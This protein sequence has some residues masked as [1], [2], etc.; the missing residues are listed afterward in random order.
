MKL[1]KRKQQLSAVATGQLIP[2]EEVKDEVFAS[3]MLGE[4]F[5]ITNHD[6][7][8]FAPCD[9]TITGIFPT[10]HAITL[11]TAK[12]DAV[13]VHMGIDTVD[14]KGAP[15]EIHVV[16]QQQVQAGSLLA[17]MD[18]AQLTAAQKDATVIVVLPEN[19]TATLLKQ[20]VAVIPQDRVLTL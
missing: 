7:Q 1:F 6:G 11:A 3:K 14:L 12:G 5:A 16:E 19:Q 13:L 9:G 18:L 10:K 20:H 15:F 2:L 8:I 4:G 17:E